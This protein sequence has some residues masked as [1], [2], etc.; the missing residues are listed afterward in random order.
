VKRFIEG[1]DRRQVTLL[2]E[3]LDDFISE[4]NP[5]RVVDV[6]VEELD[7]RKLGFDGAE[8]AATGARR[9]TRRCCSR[10]T[11]GLSA[12]TA[13]VPFGLGRRALVPDAYNGL[14]AALAGVALAMTMPGVLKVQSPPVSSAH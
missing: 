1:E 9:T 13:P 10:S 11:T 5:V 14:I 4:D 6:F 3:C 2:P 12:L 8:P 7:L